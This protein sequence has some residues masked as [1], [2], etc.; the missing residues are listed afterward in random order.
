VIAAD[1]TALP[2][3]VAE[4]GLMVSPDNAEQWAQAMSEILD[5]ENLRSILVKKGLE[6]AAQ[7][8]WDRSADILENSYRHALETTL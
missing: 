8:T 5:D 4:A 7:F 2:E 6:R 3:V 1:A